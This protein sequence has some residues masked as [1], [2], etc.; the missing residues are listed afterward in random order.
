MDVA[1][2][3]ATYK[4]DM[5]LKL[6]LLKQ[7]DEKDIETLFADKEEGKLFQIKM[8][9]RFLTLIDV[10]DE[11]SFALDPNRDFL[12][13]FQDKKEC[14]RVKGEMMDF[15]REKCLYDEKA[16]GRVMK[17]FD[18]FIQQRGEFVGHPYRIDPIVFWTQFDDLPIGNLALRLFHMITSSASAERSFSVQK[19]LT[20]NVRNGL[21]QGRAEKM[22]AILFSDMDNEQARK[23]RRSSKRRHDVNAAAEEDGLL[24]GPIFVAKADGDDEF[25]KE[26]EMIADADDKEEEDDAASN[27][28]D[29]DEQT[30][31][32][33]R[34]TIEVVPLSREEGDGIPILDADAVVNESDDADDD[35]EIR[36][37]QLAKE[38]TP[39][40]AKRS[41]LS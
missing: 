24:A 36:F 4:S 41:R 15:M 2:S 28:S 8:E 22:V 17:E 35:D 32:Q 39:S 40:P 18:D 33:S 14:R 38:A 19:R 30:A 10:T 25:A 11:L 34:T 1:Q 13:V 23:Q 3:D 7:A 31:G 6:L 37:K 20:G 12:V 29:E 21:S 27:Q 26:L 16:V 9:R 5:Y